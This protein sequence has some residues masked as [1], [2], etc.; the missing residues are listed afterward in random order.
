METNEEL[1]FTMTDKEYYLFRSILYKQMSALTML[2]EKNRVRSRIDINISNKVLKIQL[3]LAKLN[4]RFREQRPKDYE[5]ITNQ[6][7][8]DG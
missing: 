1:T 8:K 4:I 3:L 6:I 2:N 7:R 5:R